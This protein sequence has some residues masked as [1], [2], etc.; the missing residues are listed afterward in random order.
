MKISLVTTVRNEQGS[1]AALIDAIAGQTRAPDEWIVVDGG[2]TDGTR[3]L[4]EQAPCRLLVHPGNIS[5][6]RN[7]GIA[8]ASGEIIVLTDAG[9]LP[10]ADWLEQLVDALKTGESGFAAGETTPRIDTP[11]DAAQWIVLDQF[12]NPARKWRPPTV[13]ARN[14]AFRRSL[15]QACPFP[16]WLDI[17]EDRWLVEQWTR[18]S[19]P[20]AFVDQARTEWLLRPNLYQVLRQHFRYMHG[21]GRAGLRTA[22]NLAR[23]AF[24]LVVIALL[25]VPAYL[26]KAAAIGLWLAY[27]VTTVIARFRLATDGRPRWFRLRTLA[28]TP[29]VLLA[30][31][32]GKIAGYLAGLVDRL[33][34]RPESSS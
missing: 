4:L 9:C 29:A 22:R 17:G 6:G 12:W 27:L 15:W 13:S 20:P 7:R 3:A 21:D 14:L 31:D 8:E 1:I 18:Q 16:D 28:W 33:R 26:A 19:G 5:A 34:A 24:Y 32:L 11:L 23:L 25:L 2:S 30:A 10:Q